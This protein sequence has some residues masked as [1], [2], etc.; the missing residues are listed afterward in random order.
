MNIVDTLRFFRQKLKLRQKDMMAEYADPSTY[1]KI[2]NGTRSL[3]VNELEE[4]L[5]HTSINP[6][7]FFGFTSFDKEQ[8]YFREYYYYCGAHLENKTT[9]N[10]LLT[11][12]DSLKNK[13]T[14]TLRENSNYLAIK[15]FFYAHWSEVEPITEQEIADAYDS[16]LNKSFYLQYDYIITANLIRFF[17]QKQIDQLLSRMFPI[18]YENQR[19]FTTKKFACTILTNLISLC[20]YAQDYEGAAKYISLAKKQDKRNENYNFKLNLHYLTNLLNYLVDGELIYIERVYNFIQL[21]ENTG[22]TLQA[23]LVKKEVKL[24][25]YKKNE[26]QALENYTIGLLKEN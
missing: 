7:E 5:S 12:Y 3:K 25:T 10:K 19:D 4:I 17:T 11:Y 20:L 13:K 14:R 8:Q 22:D 26:Q 24:L 15:N 23:E 16:L 21:L 6:E 1:S 18:K 9:K 2:E